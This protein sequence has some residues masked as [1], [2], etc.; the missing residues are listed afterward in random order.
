MLSNFIFDNVLTREKPQLTASFGCDLLSNFIFDNVL[1]SNA[2][3]A[4]S[5][6]WLWFAFKFYLWQ[7]SYKLIFIFSNLDIVVIC[8]Q[9]LSLTTF[10]QANSG[11]LLTRFSCDL[12]SNFIFDNVLTSQAA[13]LWTRTLLWFAFKFYL[14]QRSYKASPLKRCVPFVVICFQILSLTT[15]LQDNVVFSFCENSCD[16]LS[17]FIFDNVL[18]S[19]NMKNVDLKELWFA[20]K[21]Y[22]WQRSY[23]K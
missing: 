18:T 2:T 23:K 6:C 20:F 7:R 8:F 22:L 10:L 5:P 12:L 1:T 13:D 15:F 4:A 11:S 17:N 9:I 19:D 14:W 21:F 3:V 16:L